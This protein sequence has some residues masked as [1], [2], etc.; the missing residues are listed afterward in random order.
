ME[1]TKGKTVKAGGGGAAVRKTA[2]VHDLKRDGKAVKSVAASALTRDEQIDR[3]IANM[4]R[5]A[6]SDKKTVVA[7]LQ[8]AGILDGRGK[9]AKF[10]REP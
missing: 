8:R 9:L 3:N 5:I 10:Y 4:K 2:K 6:S 1:I 7:F